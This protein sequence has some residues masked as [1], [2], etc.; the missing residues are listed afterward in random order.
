[1]LIG[2]EMVAGAGGDERQATFPKLQLLAVDVEH[3]A[4]LEDDVELIL[5][6]QHPT[7]GLWRG[8]CIDEDLKS[9]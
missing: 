8:E 6:V 2:S 1:M 5:C 4:A 7:V 9:C 3:A